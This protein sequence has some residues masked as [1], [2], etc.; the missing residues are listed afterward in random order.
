VFVAL[1][2]NV[3]HDTSHCSY[4]NYITLNQL[5]VLVGCRAAAAPVR[6]CLSRGWLQLGRLCWVATVPSKCKMVSPPV[7]MTTRMNST[8]ESSTTYFTHDSSHPI[9]LD[10]VITLR[11]LVM[12]RC[13]AAA[14]PVPLVFQLEATVSALLTTI[15]IYTKCRFSNTRCNAAHG[16]S[17]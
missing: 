15:K 4:A 5:S 10:F 16:N 12:I 8:I 3:T 6:W 2:G 14:V 11:P 17:K 13:C 9:A 1:T 7:R